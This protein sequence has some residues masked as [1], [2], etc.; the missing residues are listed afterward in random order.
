MRKIYYKSWIARLFLLGKFKTAMFFGEIHTK[1][2]TLSEKS[3]RHESIHCEQYEE[4]T[5]LAFI[6]ALGISALFG[7]VAWP[8]I[9]V[10]IFYYILYGI[11]A[12]ISWIHHFFAHRKKDGGAAA[13]KAYHN[14]M[15]EMEAYEGEDD[16]NWIQNRKFCHWFRYF[17]KV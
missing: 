1:H 17:G 12:A 4:V 2:D 11:E 5:L 16:P 15:F 10:P 14:S 13:D 6:L 8:F 7:W 3:R 9:L